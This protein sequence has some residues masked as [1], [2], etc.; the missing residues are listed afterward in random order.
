MLRVRGWGDVVW[1]NVTL[2]I[3]TVVLAIASGV[4]GAKR[5]WPWIVGSAAFILIH[6]A[7]SAARDRSIVRRLG[8]DYDRVQR[9]AVQIVA[10]LGQLAA[11]RH[12]LWMVDIY[13]PEWRWSIG[14]RR[15]VVTRALALSRQLSV[16][17]VD[18]RPQPPSVDPAIG[19]HGE[20]FSTQRP[21]V[22]LDEA[23]Y[24]QTPDNVW[25]TYDAASNSELSAAYGVLAVAP[26]VD[27]LGKNCCGVL[28]VHVKPERETVVRALGAMQSDEGRRRMHNACIDLNG[29]LSR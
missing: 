12:D 6:T 14:F 18:A 7:A 29:L 4:G 16:A 8:R 13:L 11:D 2:A 5:P 23:I 17:I 3:A 28:A 19:P 24:G 27:Q 9:R 20:C 10:D 1:G 25:S 26:L 15:P 22:W 21:L